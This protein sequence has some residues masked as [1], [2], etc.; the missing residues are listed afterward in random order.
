MGSQYGTTVLLSGI[1]QGLGAE[2]VFAAFC[3]K[4]NLPVSLAGAAQ[5]CSAG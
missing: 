5:A 2:L 1:L 4:F 3:T